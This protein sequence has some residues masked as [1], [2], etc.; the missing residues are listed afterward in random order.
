[1]NQVLVSYD[2]VIMMVHNAFKQKV[3]N[4][5]NNLS[6]NLP[7]SI[8]IMDRLSIMARKISR[9][10]YPADQLSDKLMSI[11][12]YAALLIMQAIMGTITIKDPN[13]RLIARYEDTLYL[14]QKIMVNETFVPLRFYVKTNME[15][16][17]DLILQKIIE[18]RKENKIGHHAIKELIKIINLTIFVQMKMLPKE[19]E[20]EKITRTTTGLP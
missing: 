1:M 17:S 16:L 11:V 15:S 6:E 19:D 4:F 2:T 12:D 20:K 8:T 18:L 10:K 5:K 3:D 13:D 9:G 7:Y 14:A